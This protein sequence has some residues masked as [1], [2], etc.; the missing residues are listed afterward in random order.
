MNYQITILKLQENFPK[1]LNY[2][3]YFFQ[4][5]QEKLINVKISIITYRF[6][7][8]IMFKD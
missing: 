5:D 1:N 2:Y 3:Y 8:V 7:F 6:S 4:I